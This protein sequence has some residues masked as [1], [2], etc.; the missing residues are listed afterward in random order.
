MDLKASILLPHETRRLYDPSKSNVWTSQSLADLTV[1]GDR[2]RTLD[3]ANM[4]TEVF[5]VQHSLQKSPIGRRGCVSC[6]D[7][8]DDNSERHISDRIGLPGQGHAARD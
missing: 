1:F 5:V 6:G 7:A 2:Q 4:K 8:Y 3:Q